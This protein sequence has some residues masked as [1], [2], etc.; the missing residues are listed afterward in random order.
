MQSLAA[1]GGKKQRAFNDSLLRLV[2]LRSKEEPIVI[3]SLHCAI[4]H[5]WESSIRLD[6]N[7][8][9]KRSA[10]HNCAKIAV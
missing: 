6:L 10:L 4:A 7:V 9:R 5:E 3:K 2:L 8:I 1:F